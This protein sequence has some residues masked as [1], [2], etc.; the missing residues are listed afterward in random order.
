[1]NPE[2]FG[3]EYVDSTGS[4]C[5]HEECL[6]RYECKDVFVVAK[7]LLS[8]KKESLP[9][10]PS[11][12][13][14][15]KSVR[16]KRSG[17]IKP[18]RLLYKDEGTLRDKLLFML[19]DFLEP[20]GFVVKATKCLHSFSGEDK[21]FVL[22]ADTRRKNSVLLY[23]PDALSVALVE[24]GLSCRELFDSERPN[25]PQYLRWVTVLRGQGD[26][27]KFTSAFKSTRSVQ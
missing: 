26:F 1:M 16:K 9:A 23:V 11:K 20:Q 22:K 4:E 7:G 17:Y 27:E 8:T 13:R 21:K 10:R 15:D 14:I 6:L 19:R 5:P 18:G 24:E 2:C 12:P 3:R 25:F